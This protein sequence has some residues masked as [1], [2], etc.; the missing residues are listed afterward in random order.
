MTDVDYQT[1]VAEEISPDQWAGYFGHDERPRM[2]GTRDP[3][4]DGSFSI[5]Q[6]G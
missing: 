6:D 3:E 1:G 2:S 5:G 4:G